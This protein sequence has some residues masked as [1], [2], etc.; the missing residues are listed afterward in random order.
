M[1]WTILDSHLSQFR[2]FE[3]V[4]IFGKFDFLIFNVRN[5]WKILRKFRKIFFLNIPDFSHQFSCFPWW[6]FF[7]YK[8]WENKLLQLSYV[9]EVG[10]RQ[11]HSIFIYMDIMLQ[12][13]HLFVTNDENPF[14]SLLLILVEHCFIFILVLH[15][16]YIYFCIY[17]H[18]KT[19]VKFPF[20]ESYIFMLCISKHK[21]TSYPPIDIVWNG[22]KKNVQKGLLKDVDVH[23]S[24]RMFWVSNNIRMRAQHDFFL[25]S[26]ISTLYNHAN[27]IIWFIICY[28][29]Y[30]LVTL[31]L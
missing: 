27:L 6:Y 31:V 16:S 23:N 17:L 20:T 30:L 1:E 14:M 11:S 22:K 24:Q 12:C 15:I 8:K 3:S 29:A 25:S 2:S 18:M 9:F 21:I 19:L 28:R 4:N 10:H 13:I 5:F 7:V 26:H